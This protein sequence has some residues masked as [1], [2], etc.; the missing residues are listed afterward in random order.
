MGLVLGCGGDG[1]SGCSR[2]GFKVANS[3]EVHQMGLYVYRG[4]RLWRQWV[5]GMLNR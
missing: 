4:A 5:I 1:L 3:V 2:G